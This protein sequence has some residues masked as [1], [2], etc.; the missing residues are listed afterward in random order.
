MSRTENEV[1]HVHNN[2][3]GNLTNLGRTSVQW[4]HAI[5]IRTPQQLAA[6]GAVT[7]YHAIARRGFRVNKVL[8]Y[9][10]HGALLN[11]RWPEIGESE[12]LELLA[13]LE[14]LEGSTGR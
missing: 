11:K 7:A 3:L 13:E 8:L 1:N 14:A 4:L 5:G 10:L 6:T 9:S 2:D 12:K